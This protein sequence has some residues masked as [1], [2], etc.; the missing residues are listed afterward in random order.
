[1][2]GAPIQEATEP[3]PYRV[4]RTGTSLG[5]AAFAQSCELNAI[6]VLAIALMSR[7]ATAAPRRHY[8]RYEY[9][10]V[11]ADGEQLGEV[12]RL[13]EA[14]RSNRSASGGCWRHVHC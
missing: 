13:V 3:I 9:L 7:K 14:V 8:A 4:G 10:F 2:P 12:T 1:M 6:M 11:R 5:G